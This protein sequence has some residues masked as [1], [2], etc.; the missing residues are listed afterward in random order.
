MSPT[1]PIIKIV[2]CLCGV[3]II[4][5]VRFVEE[6]QSVNTKILYEANTAVDVNWYI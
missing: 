5:P 1:K 6:L 4:F 2:Y 3:G